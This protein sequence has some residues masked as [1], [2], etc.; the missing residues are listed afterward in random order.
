MKTALIAL[1]LLLPTSAVAAPDGA[2]KGAK[3]LLAAFLKPDADC[4][5]LSK[6]L[7][8]T[9]DDYKAVFEGAAAA[10]AEAGYK[11]LWDEGIVVVA[12]GPRQTELILGSAT[13]DDIKTGGPTAKELPGGYAKVADSLKK[14]V[15][16]WRFQ[17]VEKGKTAGIAFDGLVF[18]NGH[19]VIFP[20]PWRVLAK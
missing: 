7:R 4:Q 6:T 13:T 11:K 16:F 9:R 17:F 14:G 12:P 15:T 19:W 10:K 18:V 5:T 8:P 1:A 20:K 2:E 3:E